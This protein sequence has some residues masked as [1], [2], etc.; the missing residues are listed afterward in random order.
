MGAKCARLCLLFITLCSASADVRQ[1]VPH[2]LYGPGPHSTSGVEGSLSAQAAEIQALRSV[3][4]DLVDLVKSTQPLS[5]RAGG[6]PPRQPSPPLALEHHSEPARR[7]SAFTLSNWTAGGPARIKIFTKDFDPFS[8]KRDDGRVLGYTHDFIKELLSSSFNNSEAATTEFLGSNEEI[9]AKLQSEEECQGA[10][11]CLGAAA[12]SITSNREEFLDFLPSYFE[13]GLK[14]MVKGKLG[15]A[16][17][18]RRVFEA[19]GLILIAIAAFFLFFTL[20]LFPFC[21]VFEMLL[22]Q[23]AMGLPIFISKSELDREKRRL[24]GEWVK[25]ASCRPS[26]I[27]DKDFWMTQKRAKF[28]EIQSLQNAFLWTLFIL[29]GSNVAYP[30]SFWARGVRCVG[31]TLQRAMVVVITAVA[32]TVLT[33]ESLLAQAS[34]VHSFTD[35]ANRK[36]CAIKDSEAF[37]FLS[38][39][40]HVEMHVISDISTKEEMFWLWEQFPRGLRSC[41]AVVYDWPLLQVGYIYHG[42]LNK[43]RTDTCL[44]CPHQAILVGQALNADPYGIAMPI[45]HPLLGYLQEKTLAVIRNIDLRKRILNKWKL[46]QNDIRDFTDIEGAWSLIERFAWYYLFA[47]LGLLALSGV[48]YLAFRFF[49]SK[50]DLRKIDARLHDSETTSYLLQET[51]YLDSSFVHL[52]E[53][54]GLTHEIRVQ[55]NRVQAAV[56][57]FFSLFTAQYALHIR[58]ISD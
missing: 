11:L 8:I 31:L 55:L 22:N 33:T 21:W 39:Q 1:K 12:I 10:T 35:L 2:A 47:F 44:Q 53:D 34:S 13:S 40:T 58:E 46:D 37:R 20:L 48:W 14:V 4:S 54:Y 50:L 15:I 38:S 9:F 24:E 56:V 27:P 25:I 43:T 18:M 23:D 16:T 36:V 5:M 17:I 6:T 26:N 42:D 49:R 19:V 52:S 45:Q 29:A 30:K 7:T 28:I 51:A 3:V 32:A 41:E 57:I